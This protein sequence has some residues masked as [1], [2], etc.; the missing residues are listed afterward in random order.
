MILVMIIERWPRV[1]IVAFRIF[2]F[3]YFFNNGPFLKYIFVCCS[4]V[5]NGRSV[6]NICQL[7][8][9]ELCKLALK[10]MIVFKWLFVILK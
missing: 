2:F 8:M 4:L 7:G 5:S 1:S 9:H 6:G 10:V 3:Y